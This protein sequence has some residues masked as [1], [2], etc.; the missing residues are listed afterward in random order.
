MKAL[1]IKEHVVSLA[2]RTSIRSATI[3]ACVVRRDGRREPYGVVAQWHR[4]PLKR[5]WWR[6]RRRLGIKE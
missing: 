4:N 3:S 2:R 6:L 5:L 1:K